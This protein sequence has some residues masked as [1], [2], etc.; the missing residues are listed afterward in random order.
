VLGLDA[1]AVAM[2]DA[3]R[4]S[5]VS[6][7]RASLANAAFAVA[8]L[9]NPPPELVESASLVTVH[10]PWGSLLR[11]VLGTNDV[12]LRGLAALL[13]NDGRLEAL[14]SLT[15]R[16]ASAAGV[17][18]TRLADVGAIA[19]SWAAAGL[20]LR[21]CRAATFA[22]IA[23]AGSSWARRLVVDRSRVVVRLD[24]RRTPARSGEWEPNVR[25]A[26]T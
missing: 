9:E 16:D 8:A 13:A 25:R 20:D 12:A 15:A 10:F 4:R 24:G 26:R 21:D 5:A 18:T 6:G 1:N 22:E 11:G 3:S 19:S 17:E 23:G 7:R 2:V 14:V